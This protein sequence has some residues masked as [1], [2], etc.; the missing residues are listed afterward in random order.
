M[1]VQK[2]LEVQQHRYMAKL[3]SYYL[4]YIRNQMLPPSSSLVT[5]FFVPPGLAHTTP[6]PACKSGPADPTPHF[7]E[8]TIP[9]FG[10]QF[11]PISPCN[12][13]LA[14]LFHS[15]H[16]TRDIVAFWMTSRRK[17][18]HREGALL[19]QFYRATLDPSTDWITVSRARLNSTTQLP[20]CCPGL[21]GG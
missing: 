8:A 7:N 3:Q 11:C 10:G 2:S 14:P 6:R 1:V 21:L 13:P 15:R 19:G 5:I 17:H 9:L 16:L 20:A 18:S 4:S 12:I